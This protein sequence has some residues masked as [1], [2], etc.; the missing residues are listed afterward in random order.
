M[1]MTEMA[2]ARRAK[3]PRIRGQVQQGDALNG[4]P[5]R[6][7]QTGGRLLHSHQGRSLELSPHLVHDGLHVDA[8]TAHGLGSL[9]DIGDPLTMS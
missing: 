1:V 3:G 5:S 4:Q 9:G 6:L 7:C 8:S 2:V